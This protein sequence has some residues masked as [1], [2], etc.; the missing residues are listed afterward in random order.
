MNSKAQ[1]ILDIIRSIYPDTNKI[2]IQEDTKL[3]EQGVLD[4]FSLVQLIVAIEDR[5]NVAIEMEDIKILHFQ[6]LN[7][8]VHYL[9]E[10]VKIKL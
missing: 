1:K 2:E 9:E 4:S 5:F 6:D 10:K 7:S 8:I 3:I